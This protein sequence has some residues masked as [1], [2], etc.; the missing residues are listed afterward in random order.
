MRLQ[1]KLK[2]FGSEGKALLATNFYNFETLSG[3][4]Q[5]A[6][7]NSKSVILQL[8]ESSINYLG[9]E[10][11]LSMAKVALKSY[12]VEGWVHLDHGG[13]IDIAKKCLDAGFDS[14]M[15]DASEKP[16]EENVKITS[17][18]VRYAES[19][20]ANVEAELGYVA[21][22][23]QIQQTN[24]FTQPEE[25]KRFVDA[26]GINALAIAIGSAHGFY[27]E[28]PKLQLE[29]LSR[30]HETT[31]AALVLHGGS[32]IPDDQLQQAIARGISKVNL[33]TETKNIF[34]KTLQKTL[35]DNEEID[36]RKVFPIA[37]ASVVKLIADKLHVVTP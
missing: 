18:V 35:M 7:L 3:V 29:L 11:A 33:A 17:E 37:T 15:I 5:A 2:T 6:Q 9:L 23:G 16:F 27:K 14:V 13:S 1:E 8:S 12:G 36:L 30:I 26:T 24:Q 31:D 22:L 25:A 20:K 32:G 4:L 34:M 28:A 19:Y 21:K 10:I